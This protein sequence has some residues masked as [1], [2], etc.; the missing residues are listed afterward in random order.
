MARCTA[1]MF[2]CTPSSIFDERMHRDPNSSYF[3]RADEGRNSEKKKGAIRKVFEKKPSE[4][5]K[6]RVARELDFHRAR[7]DSKPSIFHAMYTSEPHFRTVSYSSVGFICPLIFT[8]RFSCTIV[9]DNGTYGTARYEELL[10]YGTV[11][12]CILHSTVFHGNVT[13]GFTRPWCGAV[14]EFSNLGETAV[15]FLTPE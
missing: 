2:L 13:H 5:E 4:R 12:Y 6:R 8:V 10:V 11:Q 3:H 7:A 14:P 1:H 9:D 15:T